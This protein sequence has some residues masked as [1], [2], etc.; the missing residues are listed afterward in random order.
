MAACCLTK[1]ASR[2][3]GTREPLSRCIAQAPTESATCDPVLSASNTPRTAQASFHPKQLLE[4]HTENLGSELSLTGAPCTLG[5]GKP[6]VHGACCDK[7]EIKS[8]DAHRLNAETLQ[9]EP[10]PQHAW[11]FTVLCTVTESMLNILA[12]LGNAS[13][14]LIL[15][16]CLISYL[17][18]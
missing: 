15:T 13:D 1:K 2:A 10:T 9:M 3:G 8:R 18:T 12:V 11:T 16:R 6:Q 17:G 7:Q 14:T 4:Q 5:R